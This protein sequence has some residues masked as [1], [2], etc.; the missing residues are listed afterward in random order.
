MKANECLKKPG[1]VASAE[2][3]DATPLPDGEPIA[4]H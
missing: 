3:E 2:P 4:E 1:D